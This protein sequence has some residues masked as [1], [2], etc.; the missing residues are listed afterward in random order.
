MS[1]DT[2]TFSENEILLGNSD[3]FKDSISELE[4]SDLFEEINRLSDNRDNRPLEDILKEA[5]TLIE[6][7]QNVFDNQVP[8]K[9]MQFFSLSCESTPME[10]RTLGL[11]DQLDLNEENP[12]K[13]ETFQEEVSSLLK[14]HKTQL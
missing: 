4:I 13:L 11:L 7:Q 6:K 2:S 3:Y 10:M 1:L 14:F 9:S 12:E 8:G 5:E